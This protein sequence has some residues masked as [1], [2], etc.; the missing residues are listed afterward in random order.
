MTPNEMHAHAVKIDTELA[1]LWS[2]RGK[3]H[4]E[5]DSLKLSMA[6]AVGIKPEYVT[7]NRREVR[8]SIDE[9]RDMLEIKLDGDTIP[10]YDRE[11]CERY[12]DRLAEIRDEL[13]AVATLEK[14]LNDDFNEKQWS[15]FFLVTNQN[16]HIHSAMSCHSCNIRTQFAWLP[17]L[18]GLTEKD[19]VDAHGTVLCSHCFPSA[20]VEWTLGIQKAADPNECPGSGTSDFDRAPG[21]RRRYQVCKH[22]NT[23]QNVTSTGKLRKHKRESQ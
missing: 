2:L 17:E 7:R 10:R 14:P 5:L 8:Q 4:N 20:P 11:R 21:D 16:G 18:S 13:A 1:R 15:R 19:A 3:L 9:L 12:L 22:C 6:Y 23:S